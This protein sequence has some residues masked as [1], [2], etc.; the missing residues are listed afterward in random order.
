MSTG[1]R[2]YLCEKSITDLGPAAIAADEYLLTHKLFGKS[3]NVPKVEH[4]KHDKSVG[5]SQV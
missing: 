3:H 1:V 2:T 5:N 4:T